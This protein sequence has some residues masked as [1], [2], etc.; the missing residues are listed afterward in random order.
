MKNTSTL[1]AGIEYKLR[2]LVDK[3]ESL[4]KEIQL[5]T[6]RISELEQAADQQ[7]KTIIKLEENIN[8]IKIAKS[9]EPGK[10]TVEART[11]INEL[12]REIDRCIGLLNK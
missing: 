2:K 9:L 6:E 1:V 10:G 12:V 4:K 11:K 5:K 8:L 3:Y 7:H